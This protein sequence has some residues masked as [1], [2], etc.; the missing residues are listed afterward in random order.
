M[1]WALEDAPDVPPKLLGLLL[2]LANHVDA[3]GK[4]AYPTIDRLAYYARKGRRQTLND[5]KDLIATGL[6]RVGDQRLV[7]HLDPR[8]RPVVYDLAMERR[9][10]RYVRAAHVPEQEPTKAP[11]ITPSSDAVDGTPTPP[12]G[13]ADDIQ[14]CSAAHP[15]VHSTAPEPSLEPSIKTP[16][17]SRHATVTPAPTPGGEDDLM[18]ETVLRHQPRWRRTSVIAAIRQAI[19]DGMQVEVAHKVMIDLA[20]GTKYGPTTAGPQRLLA[21]GPWWQPGEVFIPAKTSI[22]AAAC[23]KHPNEPADNC[24]CCAGERIAAA[25][26]REPAAPPTRTPP[27]DLVRKLSALSGYKF[28]SAR[29]GDPEHILAGTR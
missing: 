16:P 28:G 19:A 14:G 29:G 23:P 7:A 22:S 26:P 24:S 1:V 6:I 18:I 10:P 2:G 4:G 27:K 17:S 13:A 3:D 15:G 11:T 12:R 25:T 9:R 5:I 21:K 20:E 8:Y